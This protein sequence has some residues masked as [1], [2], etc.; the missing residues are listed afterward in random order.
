MDLHGPLQGCCLFL[1]YLLLLTFMLHV[2]CPVSCFVFYYL[3]TL[4]NAARPSPIG[5]SATVCPIV[6]A[7]N[8]G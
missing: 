1:F 4:W 2:F 6:P 7:P 5:T 8:D 3:L